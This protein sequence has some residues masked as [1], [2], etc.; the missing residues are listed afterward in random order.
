MARTCARCGRVQASTE[1]ETETRCEACDAAVVADDEPAASRDASASASASA[2]DDG[3]TTTTRTWNAFAGDAMCAVASASFRG[4][5]VVA[6]AAAGAVAAAIAA[7]ATRRSVLASVGVG[8]V[9]GAATAFDWAT[10]VG[11]ATPLELRI[12]YRALRVSASRAGSFSSR[13]PRDRTADVLAR[14][15]ESVRA[16]G[17]ERS[18]ANGDVERAVREIISHFF[19]RVLYTGPHT[20]ASAW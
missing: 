14:A 15:L 9:T 8:A 12:A 19:R 18:L 6:G 10:F 16:N 11:R 4:L 1:D 17:I 3:E 20:T 7:R 2:S 13:Y 5:V